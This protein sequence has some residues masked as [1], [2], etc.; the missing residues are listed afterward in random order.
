MKLLKSAILQNIQIGNRRS[1]NTRERERERER[2]VPVSNGE[3]SSGVGRF[4]VGK[5]V[6]VKEKANDFVDRE[7]AD[8]L[9]PHPCLLSIRFAEGS[10]LAKI[11]KEKI[12]LYNQIT[13]SFLFL[14][15]VGKLYNFFF[16]LTPFGVWTLIANLCALLVFL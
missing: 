15:L 1:G 16:G 3:E 13:R 8:D 9:H 6:V 4:Y 12:K 7:S 11:T 2:M 10:A 5:L 14:S